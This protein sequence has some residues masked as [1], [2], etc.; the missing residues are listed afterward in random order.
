LGI[1]QPSFQ[2]QA[3]PDAPSFFKGAAFFNRK[4]PF[5]LRSEGGVG[6]I[7]YIYSRK[8]A[9]TAIAKNVLKELDKLSRKSK[10]D[11][12]MAVA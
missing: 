9:R 12:G 10:N 3:N 7:D 1:A 6:H 8:K 5:A 2:L 4:A 11:R